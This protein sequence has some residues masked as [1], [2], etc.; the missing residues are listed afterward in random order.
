MNIKFKR[1]KN[2]NCS[3]CF[4]DLTQGKALALCNAIR[5][6]A[7]NSAVCEDFILPIRRA[8][9]EQHTYTFRDVNDQ[10]FELI[11]RSIE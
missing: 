2:G 9:D 7:Q 10:L 8:I 1:Y 4:D 5:L 11:S 6:Y 3:F